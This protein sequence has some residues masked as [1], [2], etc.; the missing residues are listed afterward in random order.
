MTLIEILVVSAIMLTL[1][2]VS[3]PVLAPIAESRAAREASRGVQSAFESAR[4][5]AMR[6][7]RPCGVALM[8]FHQDFPFGCITLEQLTAPPS[9]VAAYSTSGNSVSI[10]TGSFPSLKRGDVVQLNHTGPRFVMS[11][12]SNS[13][14]LTAWSDSNLGLTY[15]Y[16]NFGTDSERECTISYF[17]IPDSSNAFAKALGIESSF[18]LPKGYIVDLA[19]SGT[20]NGTWQ[21]TLNKN[22]KTLMKYPPTVVFNADGTASLF[23]NGSKVSL[24]NL[25][26]PK[27]YLLVGSWGKMLDSN[28]NSIADEEEL[29][30]TNLQDTNS[31]WVVVN[32]K[33]GL[34]T[35]ARNIDK[36]RDSVAV[37]NQT[38][39]KGGN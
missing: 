14:D 23:I 6:L 37:T 9:V 2:A 32:P 28:G 39:T 4:A 7:G 29:I 30:R 11:G 36:T 1:M 15:D 35:T 34:V 33:T 10:Q 19:Y 17:P 5:R 22:T 25:S 18:I 13:L 16:Q 31:F 26:D 3:V 8:P 38:N 21:G 12:N 27:I 24:E 20:V